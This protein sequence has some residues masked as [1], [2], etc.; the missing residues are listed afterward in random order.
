MEPMD[1]LLLV[2]GNMGVN[3]EDSA[4]K[5]EGFKHYVDDIFTKVDKVR[6]ISELDLRLK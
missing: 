3:I 6:S 2:G 4:T 5:V 1:E